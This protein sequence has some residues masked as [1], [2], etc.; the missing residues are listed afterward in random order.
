MQEL[1]LLSVL[2]FLTLHKRQREGDTICA[3]RHAPITAHDEEPPHGAP[4]AI[5]QRSIAMVHAQAS[6]AAHQ[7]FEKWE[8]E[9][10]HTETRVHRDPSRSRLFGFAVKA[11]ATAI[12][13]LTTWQRAVSRRRAIADLPPEQLEDIGHA[14]PPAPVLEVKAGLITILKSLR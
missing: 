8:A 14:Q 2:S 1:A 5:A 7:V 4:M 6:I 10:P 13:A 3:A 12:A 11:T 9:M